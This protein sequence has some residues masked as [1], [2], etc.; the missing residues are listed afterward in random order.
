MRLVEHADGHHGLAQVVHQAGE[1]GFAGVGLVEPELARQGHHQGAHRHGV[2]VGV[3]VAG[4]QARQADDGARVARHRA[5]DVVDQGQAVLGVDGLAQAHVL[6]HGLHG[7]ARLGHDARGAHHLVLEA[8]G[9]LAGAALGVQ[10]QLGGRLQAGAILHLDVIEVGGLRGAGRR[11]LD[12]QP[13]A[14]VDHDVGHGRLQLRE[15]PGVR[16]LERAAP[17]RVRQPGAGHLVHVHANAKLM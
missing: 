6:E 12:V 2:H 13:L 4:F 16:E 5:G 3:V 15:L 11:R 17:E 14:R 9:G 8:G 1:A 7:T 10:L